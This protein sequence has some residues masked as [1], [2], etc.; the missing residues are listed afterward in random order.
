MKVLV[1]VDTGPESQMALGYACHLLEHF[2]AEVHA[3]HVMPDQVEMAADAFYAPFFS[4]AGL[5]EWIQA[6]ELQI[7]EEVTKACDTCL[8]GK[9]PCEPEITN[10]DPAEEIL[11]R[12]EAGDFDLIVLGSHGRSS[13]RGLLLGAVHAKVL[14]HSKIPVLI[15][16]DFREIKRVL[17]AYRGSKCD[18]LALK[19]IGPL[20][21]RRKPEITIMN[22]YESNGDGA[23]EAAEACVLDGKSALEE[24]GHAPRV[25]TETGDFVEEILKDVAR[26]RYDLLV[27]GAYGDEKGT[28]LRMLSD[29]ALN[30][31][32]LTNR[33][34]LVFREREGR[35]E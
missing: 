3:L 26:S 18:Q 8:A 16:R 14:H 21:S 9:V 32:R 6:E 25:K 2:D 1:A 29:E 15:V 34:I 33:P 5:S 19:F 35:S 30:L 24:W 7:N 17:V 13:L 28:F 27:L 31:V 23:P 11:E 10:G 4:K 20:L 12:A 22:V